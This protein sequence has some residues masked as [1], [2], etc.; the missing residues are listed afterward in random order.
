MKAETLQELIIAIYKSEFQ[1]GSP[2][3]CWKYE[4]EKYQLDGE[5][6]PPLSEYAKMVNNIIPIM[7]SNGTR[8][9]INLFETGMWAHFADGDYFRNAVG[10]AGKISLDARLQCVHEYKDILRFFG[11]LRIY[12]PDGKTLYYRGPNGVCAIPIQPLDQSILEEITWRTGSS[13]VSFALDWI[14]DRVQ[15]STGLPLAKSTDSC[16]YDVFI[17]HKSQDFNFAKPI[18]EFLLSQNLNVFLSEESLPKLGSA[19][20][21]K[22]IDEALENSKH[23]ILIVSLVEHIKS[24]WVEAE[25]RVFIN[26][27]RSGRK[28][29]NFLTV[30]VGDLTPDK[31]PISLRYYEVIPYEIFREKILPYVTENG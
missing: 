7:L 14:S 16:Y 8:D 6:V 23:M 30:T 21:M 25:W 18:Y 17:S 26:E 20:Y 1:A 5:M 2:V 12:H 13:H 15:P 19:D 31:L 24:S 28:G 11:D 22:R 29:G 9:E 3:R 4:G 10:I 27:K